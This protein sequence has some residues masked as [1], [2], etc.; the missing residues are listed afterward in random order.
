[1]KFEDLIQKPIEDLTDEDIQKIVNDLSIDELNRLEKA[2]KNK[3]IRPKRKRK[4][5]NE[6]VL[7]EFDKIVGV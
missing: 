4:S 2:I 5:K 6:D 7:D 1:M 3:T